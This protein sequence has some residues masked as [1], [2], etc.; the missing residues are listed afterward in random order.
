MEVDE[1]VDIYNKG[2]MAGE[3]HQRPSPQTTKDISLLQT[4]FARM[5]E[6]IDNLSMRVEEKFEEI[7]FSLKEVKESKADKWVEGFCKGS[8]IILCSSFLGLLAYLAK[9]IFEKIV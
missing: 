3:A 2:F 8:M 4:N 7:L 1:K 5:E 9:F 6:K